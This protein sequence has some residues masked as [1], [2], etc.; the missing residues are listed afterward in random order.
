MKCNLNELPMNRNQRGLSGWKAAIT[1]MVLFQAL[2][3]PFMQ[4]Y[5][6]SNRE[7]PQRGSQPSTVGCVDLVCFDP[8]IT[9]AKD[10]QLN[11]HLLLQEK[12]FVSS[13]EPL[14][15]MQVLFS[16]AAT[17]ARNT[18][19]QNERQHCSDHRAP[20]AAASIKA[21]NAA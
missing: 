9:R 12:N 19:I 13:L 21:P 20:G 4:A 18:G 17:K 3:Q 6:Q 15:H 11:L 7:P 16:C 2:H 5:N 14:G 10:M 8:R 1:C